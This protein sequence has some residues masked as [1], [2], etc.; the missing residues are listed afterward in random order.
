MKKIKRSFKKTAAA[1]LAAGLLIGAATPL[2]ANGAKKAEKYPP[3]TITA[4][5]T[6]TVY[7]KK[8]IPAKKAPKQI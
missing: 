1:V 2:S 5:A 8:S 6:L 4:T 3:Y 7:I